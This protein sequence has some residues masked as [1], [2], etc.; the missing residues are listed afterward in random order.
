MAFVVHAIFQLFMSLYVT[1]ALVVNIIMNS[2][3]F[4]SVNFV[5]SIQYPSTQ[6]N[7]IYIPISHYLFAT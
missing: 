1:V 2:C 3:I 5:I 4:L 6:A 7:N